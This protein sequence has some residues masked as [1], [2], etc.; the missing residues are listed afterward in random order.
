MAEVI[1]PSFSHQGVAA[2]FKVTDSSWVV[3][4]NIKGWVRRR[5]YRLTFATSSQTPLRSAL[6]N[7]L[8]AS[9]YLEL[10]DNWMVKLENASW[11]MFG[12]RRT[13]CFAEVIEFPPLAYADEISLLGMAQ[14][15][16]RPQTQITD[17]F[18]GHRKGEDYLLLRVGHY[19][20]EGIS[21][22]GSRSPDTVVVP[23]KLINGVLKVI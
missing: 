19:V 11:R 16:S 17:A 9:S 21:N 13:H 6:L 18:I 5:R 12:F 4:V 3:E 22:M 15:K 7:C 10:A 2:D 1:N 20:S 23:L 14:T 8:D